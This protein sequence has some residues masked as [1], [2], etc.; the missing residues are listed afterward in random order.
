[1]SESSTIKLTRE[2]QLFAD[3][4]RGLFVQACPGAGKTHTIVVRTARIL[5]NLPPRRGV[6][7]ISFTNS[8]V[9]KFRIQC[10]RIGLESALSHPSFMGT[11]DAFVRQFIVLPSYGVDAR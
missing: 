9:E 10:R 5:A 3:E 1:M 8:A 2:Q 6:A 11:M 4:P 7:I